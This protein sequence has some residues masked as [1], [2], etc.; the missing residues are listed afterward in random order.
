M[1][2]HTSTLRG[3]VATEHRNSLARS[4]LARRRA[5]NGAGEADAYVSPVRSTRRERSPA[6]A[7]GR[8]RLRR[9]TRSA[10]HQLAITQ[11]NK[12]ARH[13]A[14]RTRPRP[15]RRRLSLDATQ[16]SSTSRYGQLS[17]SG[18]CAAV[19]D[20]IRA[21]C[22]LVDR[23]DEAL[24]LLS[25]ATR[26]RGSSALPSSDSTPET[27]L[28][29]RFR[30]TCSVRFDRR[31]TSRRTITLQIPP[32]FDQSTGRCNLDTGGLNPYVTTIFLR[33]SHRV[34]QRLATGR[35]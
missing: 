10:A 14:R 11:R 9:S 30:R 27:I 35:A 25:Y 12:S 28:S 3:L 16:A 17:A 21:D 22:P 13:P 33:G 32:T 8:A 2:V 29:G 1:N 6:A 31:R 5:H 24:Y 7:L 19:V 20:D 18:P 26:A 34:L 15:R 4:T 23:L